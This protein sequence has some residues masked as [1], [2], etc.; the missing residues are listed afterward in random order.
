M[1]IKG[2]PGSYPESDLVGGFAVHG[3]NLSEN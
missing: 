3:V 2:S 1:C